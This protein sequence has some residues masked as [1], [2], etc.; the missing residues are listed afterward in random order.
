MQMSESGLV[1]LTEPWEEFVA[2][3][4][5]DLMGKVRGADGKLAYREWKG[6][7]LR[8]T[9]TIG[10]GHTNAAGP[11]RY[12]NGS[13]A[14]S[15][16][17]IS[18]GLRLTE[19]QARQILLNDMAPVER[20]VDRALKVSVSQHQYDSVCDLTFNCPSALPHVSRLI[21]AG[22]WPAAERVMLEYVLSKG[23][24]LNGLVRRRAAEIAWANTHDI[25]EVAEAEPSP[26]SQKP[27]SKAIG[28]V[29]VAGLAATGIAFGVVPTDLL[30]SHGLAGAAGVVAATFAAFIWHGKWKRA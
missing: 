7:P 3:P 5:D 28:H 14:V 16:A 12:T 30:Q 23:Q 17:R 27:P 13:A 26:K 22:N 1:K 4:Y 21:N 15:I 19:D 2:Y 18:P 10:F 9:L 11:M 25:P 29:G 8:G 20:M 24:R 6:G